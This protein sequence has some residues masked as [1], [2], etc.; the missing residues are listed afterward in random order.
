[1][2]HRSGAS[3]EHSVRSEMGGTAIGTRLN[4]PRGT[5]ERCA[6]RLAQI[7]GEPITLAPDLVEATQ[8]TQPFVTYS[9]VLKSS[10]RRAVEDLR[11]PSAARLPVR[12]RSSE[13]NLLPCSPAQHH[14][15]QGQS[16]IPEVVEPSLFQSHRECLAVTLA[17]EAGQ[18]QLN[19]DGARS[20]LLHPQSQTMLMNAASTL[21]QTLHRQ[22]YRKRGRVY[23]QLRGAQHQRGDR[24]QSSVG[25]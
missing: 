1:M 15:R 18:L 14:A 11:R 10:G 6:K 21:A 20:C 4:A 23:A 12:G 8:D 5:L 22:H 3:G 7:T 16:L 25:L 2:N 24:P 19:V 17:A 9:S 13:I